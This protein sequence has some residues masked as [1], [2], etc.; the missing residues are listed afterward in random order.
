ME[1]SLP[2]DVGGRP[3]APPGPARD[4][5]AVFLPPAAA[6]PRYPRAGGARR[7]GTGWAGRDRTLPTPAPFLSFLLSEELKKQAEKDR[8]EPG[9]E[10]SDWAAREPRRAA[11]RRCALPTS[12]PRSPEPAP[13]A[14]L[15]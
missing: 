14:Y 11:R 15:A 4:A 7:R 12:L 6:G 5:G 2:R 13:P 9:E 1:D 8:G 3:A 10:E